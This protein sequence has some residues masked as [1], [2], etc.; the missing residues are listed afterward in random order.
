MDV[1]WS[2]VRGS[3]TGL[4]PTQEEII[5][6]KNQ[7]DQ[8]RVYWGELGLSLAMPKAHLLFD[9]HLLHQIE[10]FGGLADKADDAIE[11]AHQLWNREAKRTANIKNFHHRHATQ[12][13]AFWRSMSSSVRRIQE[14]ISVQRKR[15]VKRKV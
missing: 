1:I 12:Q 2:T 14:N 10:M 8:A 5:E 3:Q 9:G 7:I 4:L 6:L 15:N 11:K 13:R